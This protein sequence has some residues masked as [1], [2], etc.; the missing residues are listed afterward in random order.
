MGPPVL[1]A[2]AAISAS[3]MGG[4][5]PALG[6]AGTAAPSSHNTA[7][8]SMPQIFAARR[9]ISRI[10]ARAASIV[11]NPTANVTRL[12]SVMSLKPSALVSAITVRTFSYGTP[13]S[14]A[15]II[16][17]DA[18]EPPISGLPST[19]PTVPSSLIFSDT[20]VLPP[21]LNQNPQDSPR[22]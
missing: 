12:P 7:S 17:I 2:T 6:P 1:P 18:R 19:T 15:A 3:V 20:Q 14:S 5:V 4:C 21:K 10:A 22:P 11:A 8:S 16:E 9:H 13:N